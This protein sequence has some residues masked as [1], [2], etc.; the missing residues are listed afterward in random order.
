M[1]EN[2]TPTASGTTRRTFPGID[3]AAFQ[4]PLDR[5]ATQQLKRLYGF[6]LLVAK[7]LELRFEKLLYIF[8]V[9]NSVR[10][11]EKQFPKLYAMLREGCE[12]LDMPEPE[13]YVSQ[14]P[15]VNAY[16]FGH[17]NPYIVMFTGMLNLMDDDET[18][19]VIAHELGHIKCGHVLYN[20][21]ANTI[22]DLLAIVGQA[23]LGVGTLIG[24]G[25]EA[26]LINWRRRAELSADR[27]SLAVIQNPDIC[28]SL[29]AKLAGGSLKLADQL[30]PEEFRN[31][32]RLLDAELDKGLLEKL[33]RMW[34]EAF[35][36]NHPFAVER[37]REIDAWANSQEW[38][39]I[40][41]G[42]Y[43]QAVRKVQIRVQAE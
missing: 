36:G 17:T 27:A 10:V 14:R 15:E 16:T 2:P 41:A 7:F 29:L 30:N 13:L 24:L 32:A 1:A 22:R 9:A 11:G 34:A 3:S 21:M 5:E 28:N 43:P 18:M 39:D 4:H 25:I 31:Q 38:A 40:M 35:Q 26:A 6:D 33:Y 20:T 8:N 23:T 42:S 37:A 19:A 12:I